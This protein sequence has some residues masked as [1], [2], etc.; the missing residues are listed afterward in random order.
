MKTLAA[1][2]L[3][4]VLFGCSKT[5]TVGPKIDPA[6]YLVIPSDTVMLAGTRLDS[7]ETTDVYKKY[8]SQRGIPQIDEF[9]KQT[10]IDPR[11]DLWQLLYISNGKDSAVMGR[12]MFSDEGEPNLQK[13]GATRFSYKGLTFVGDDQT[14]ILLIGPTVVGV[15]DT[16][17]L[18]E[19]ADAKDKSSGPPPAMAELMRDIPPEAQFW[20]A[21]R[22]GPIQMP[23]DATGNLS[24]INQVVRLIQSGTLYLD[25]TSGIKGAAV[26]PGNNEK[27]AGDLEAGLKALVGFGRLS[28]PP[29]EQDLQRIWDGLTVTRQDRVVKLH[30]DEPPELVDRALNLLMGRGVRPGKSK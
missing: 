30:I 6:L 5:P 16:A 2:S 22:G 28:T 7:I 18:K 15:G 11:K 12:A 25:L 19:I 29:K 4:L 10:G 23:F 26:A 24:N 8:L 17:E 27:D 9:A 3:L 1:S 20:V 14:A 21:Y 13:K